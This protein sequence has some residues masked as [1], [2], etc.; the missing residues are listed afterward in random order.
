MRER[1]INGP[2]TRATELIILVAP[3]PRLPQK[4]KPSVAPACNSRRYRGES[5]G[6]WM[7]R[8]SWK[9]DST[10]VTVKYGRGGEKE[11]RKRVLESVLLRCCCRLLSAPSQLCS[12]LQHLLGE[13]Q[14][15][16]C[17]LC[18]C[19]CILVQYNAGVSCVLNSCSLGSGRR[20]ETKQ[21]RLLSL[22]QDTATGLAGEMISS[23][24]NQIGKI[25]D[26]CAD[27]C[28]GY[29]FPSRQRYVWFL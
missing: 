25:C 3:C 2:L 26:V 17:S 14:G 22:L 28:T 10:V 6:G 9:W 20:G 19:V 15:M 13:T 1:G 5:L 27:Y 11:K 24:L 12:L 8:R 23:S 18:G 21:L 7:M 16:P 29:H 4:R